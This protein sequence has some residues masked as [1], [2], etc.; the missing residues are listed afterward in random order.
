MNGLWG[1][2]VER[3]LSRQIADFHTLSSFKIYAEN[4]N[5]S[6]PYFF[7]EQIIM[8]LNSNE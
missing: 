4:N 1:E 5:R 6:I 3:L 7:P 8:K 2:G